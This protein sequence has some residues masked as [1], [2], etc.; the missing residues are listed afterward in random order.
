MFSHKKNGSWDHVAPVVVIGH[1]YMGVL[2][3]KHAPPVSIHICVV[4]DK[5]PQLR[6]DAP[7]SA[8]WSVNFGNWAVRGLQNA[9]NLVPGE[10]ERERDVIIY[11]L[12]TLT[13]QFPIFNQIKSHFLIILGVSWDHGV[14]SIFSHPGTPHR[15]TEA[16]AAL[17]I[18]V[19]FGQPFVTSLGGWGNASW[20]WNRGCPNNSIYCNRVAV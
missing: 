5:A 6:L 3:P 15:A 4:W 7:G 19:P 8:S 13:C 14:S 1:R 16:L 17:R 20:V 11:I 12:Y 2:R 10:G 9:M 18:A